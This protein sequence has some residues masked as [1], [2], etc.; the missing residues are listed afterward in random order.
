LIFRLPTR[1]ILCRQAE[2]RG[3]YFIFSFFLA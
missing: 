2:N 1:N 3:D